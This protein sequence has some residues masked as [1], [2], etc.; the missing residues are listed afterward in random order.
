MSKIATI[1]VKETTSE[2]QA[3]FGVE[4]LAVTVNVVT[5]D[6]VTAWKIA[7]EDQDQGDTLSDFD[8]LVIIS[9]DGDTFIGTLDDAG[10]FPKILVSLR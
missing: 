5:L 1:N 2:I 6:G 8:D 3:E 7:L 9:S 4:E 10:W